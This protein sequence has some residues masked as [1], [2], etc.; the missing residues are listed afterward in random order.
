[1]GIE[2]NFTDKGDRYR[3]DLAWLRKEIALNRAG[4][5]IP[6]TARCT[7]AGAGQSTAVTLI[8]SRA[9]V[10]LEGFRNETV[11]V[12]FADTNPVLP[13]VKFEYR[14]PFTANYSILGAWDDSL[15]FRGVWDYFHAIDALARFAPTATFGPK[16]CRGFLLMIFAI[17]EATR[18]WTISRAVG[19]SLDGEAPFRF[20]DWKDSV[21]NWDSLS[22]GA[23]RGALHGVI[24]PSS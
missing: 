8:V 20:V 14:L 13:G 17:S 15:S 6:V 12:R 11:G 1:M 21:N 7:P 10:W 5:D 23:Q 3:S 22:E 9:K 2:I 16:E 4:Q 24:L 18:F 19:K